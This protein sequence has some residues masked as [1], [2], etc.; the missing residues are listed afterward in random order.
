MRRYIFKNQHL[1]G[2]VYKTD[3]I[4]VQLIQ[5]GTK[6]DRCYIIGNGHSLSLD[7]EN[8]VTK[9]DPLMKEFKPDISKEHTVYAF[10]FT[11]ECDGLEVSSYEISE[12]VNEQYDVYKKIILVGHSKCGVCLT[13][14]T[15]FCLQPIYLVTIS[16]PFY[17]TVVAEKQ[18]AEARLK[19]KFYIAIYNMIF[20][21]HKVDRD[22]AT[23]SEFLDTL[24]KP[25]CVKH[26]NIISSFRVVFD[27]KNL[28]DLA[29]YKTNQIMNLKGD[30]VVPLA[31]QVYSKDCK[32]IGLFCSHASSLKQ[33]LK[34]V[35]YEEF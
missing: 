8:K 34:I 2:V 26:L 31:S 19:N 11:F 16:T 27:C 14:A 21:N 5:K 32:E 15:Y 35:E 10:Y 23:T 4:I 20:S 9:R 6:N 13:N 33:G 1:A 25:V 3:N 18:I 17:G 12:F 29:L 7:D 24:I 22:I 30:G 28:T